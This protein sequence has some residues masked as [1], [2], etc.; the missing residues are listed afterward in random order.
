MAL[1][2][3]RILGIGSGFPHTVVVAM[4][5][6][7]GKLNS[8][9]IVKVENQVLHEE[10]LKKISIVSPHATVNIIRDYKVAE[11]HHVSL[12]QELRG[13]LK[14]P[15]RNCISNDAQERVS[16]FFICEREEPAEFRCHYCGTLVEAEKAE[17]IA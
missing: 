13:I 6:S 9:D 3:L 8:K 11:K 5:V 2:V 10:A 7:S 17:I 4:N 12:P 1:A 15:N 14:C 16:S